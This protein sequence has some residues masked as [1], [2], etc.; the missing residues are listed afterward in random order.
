[1]KPQ[2]I[3]LTVDR[4]KRVSLGGLARYAHYL[5]HVDEDGVITLTP[6]VV[7]TRAEFDVL[8]R[9]A[10]K[11]AAMQRALDDEPPF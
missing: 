7:K 6:A 11:G 3:L 5:V 2:E 1:V 4:R 8:L 9:S 10:A